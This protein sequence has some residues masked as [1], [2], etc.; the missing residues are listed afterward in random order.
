MLQLLLDH[1]E[2]FGDHAKHFS[3]G[4]ILEVRY[5]PGL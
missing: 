3:S 4:L 2:G 5:L 1:P